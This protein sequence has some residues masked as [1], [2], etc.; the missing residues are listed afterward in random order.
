MRKLRKVKLFTFYYLVLIFNSKTSNYLE[1]WFWNEYGNWLAPNHLSVSFF[2]FVFKEGKRS[3]TTITEKTQS[4]PS[5]IKSHRFVT[6]AMNGFR[7][8][9]L[10]QLIRQPA[11]NYIQNISPIKYNWEM[12]KDIAFSQRASQTITINT[13]SGSSAK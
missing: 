4:H 5:V 7:W 11:V 1:N 10:Q 2:F 3:L 6:A 9:L 12:F 8:K 13:S